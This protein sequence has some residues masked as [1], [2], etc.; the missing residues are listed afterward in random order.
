MTPAT[1]LFHDLALQARG[2]G[3]SLLEPLLGHFAAPVESDRLTT[4]LPL[5]LEGSLGAQ[6]PPL[7][8]PLA[9]LERVALHTSSRGFVITDGASWV[10]ASSEP[11]EVRGELELGAP[12]RGAA[13]EVAYTAL[14]VALRALGVYELHAAA[15]QA[16]GFSI[17]IIG[18]SGAGK[19]TMATALIEAGCGYLGDDR[20]LLRRRG[21]ALELLSFPVAFRLTETTACA[22][23][24]LKL[25]LRAGRAKQE[26]DLRGA[27]PGQHVPLAS[28]PCFVLFPMRAHETAFVPVPAREALARIMAQSSSLV[29]PDHPAPER[30]LAALAAL[31]QSRV[32]MQARLG[33]EWLTAP[34]LAARDL[35]ARCVTWS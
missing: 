24:R 19:T 5:E 27:F 12:E 20:V 34:V 21:G 32:T 15:V 6:P 11:L 4:T 31:A 3:V 22:F 26:L 23:P 10:E 17:V 2:A 28:G 16:S 35:L 25:W 13:K 7:G 29:V 30:Q 33:P 18:D 9:T 14:L 1:I 8:E